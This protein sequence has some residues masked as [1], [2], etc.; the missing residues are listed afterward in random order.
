M[1]FASI[2][3]CISI[4]GIASIEPRDASLRFRFT[5]KAFAYKMKFDALKRQGARSDLTS[6]QVA[7]KLSTEIIAEQ[8]NTS[9]DTIK[10][11]IRLQEIFI[12]IL[13]KTVDNIFARNRAVFQRVGDKG[14]ACIV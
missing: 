9:K 2:F 13:F 5:K 11:Y 6:E 3:I 14:Q 1:H 8:E 7:P 4:I 12:D 10:R